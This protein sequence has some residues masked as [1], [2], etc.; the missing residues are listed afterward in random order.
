MLSLDLQN[1]KL[2]EPTCGKFV[3]ELIQPELQHWRN[4]ILLQIDFAELDCTFA[5]TLIEL[6]EKS[7]LS[8]DDII[9]GSYAI[10]K[11]LFY[12]KKNL[13][14][15]LTSMETLVESEKFNGSHKTAKQNAVP[16]F[17]ALDIILKKM[18]KFI[19]IGC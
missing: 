1:L 14:K 13:A 5:N 2:N 15:V 8:K 6:L 11:F 4:K 16:N 17:E 19:L 12:S 3:H 9:I 7:E 18:E 10:A